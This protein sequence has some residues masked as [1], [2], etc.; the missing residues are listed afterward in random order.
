MKIMSVTSSDAVFIYDHRNWLVY[1]ITNRM[2]G[3][4]VRL[5]L[6]NFTPL[7]TRSLLS[8]LPSSASELWDISYRRRV[9]CRS[10]RQ[11]EFRRLGLCRANLELS[12]SVEKTAVG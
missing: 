9:N 10:R 3:R 6:P 12:R 7:Q 1:P 4:L 2:I 5:S 8:E 11:S